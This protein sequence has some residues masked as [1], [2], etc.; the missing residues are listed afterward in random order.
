[1]NFHP[2]QAVTQ[3]QMSSATSKVLTAKPIRIRSFTTHIDVDAV[4]EKI[5]CGMLYSA[6]PDPMNRAL[7]VFVQPKAA[8]EFFNACH[9]EP[10]IVDGNRLSVDFVLREQALVIPPLLAREI[11][12]SGWTRVLGVS[13]PSNLPDAWIIRPTDFYDLLDRPNGGDLRMSKLDQLSDEHGVPYELYT[14]QYS[15]VALCIQAR[16]AIELNMT[17]KWTGCTTVRLADPCGG[18]ELPSGSDSTP[19]SVDTIPADPRTYP[20]ASAELNAPENPAAPPQA[21]SRFGSKTTSV[22]ITRPQVKLFARIDP[23]AECKGV[24]TNSG[25]GETG[26]EGKELPLPTPTMPQP[27][28]NGLTDIASDP[29]QITVKPVTTN[30]TGR[31]HLQASSSSVQETRQINN[32][33]LVDLAR[34]L[35]E[36]AM[37][38]AAKA[39]AGESAF[40]NEETLALL[41]DAIGKVVELKARLGNGLQEE[42]LSRGDGEKV[43]FT[44]K[45]ETGPLATSNGASD[46]KRKHQQVFDIGGPRTQEKEKA[47]SAAPKAM[48]SPLRNMANEFLDP[49][50]PTPFLTAASVAEPSIHPSPTLSITEESTPVMAP[51]A[52][53]AAAQN[54]TQTQSVESTAETTTSP[55]NP[56][57]EDS[58]TAQ[59]PPPPAPRRKGRG[60][61]T[62]GR[63]GLGASKWAN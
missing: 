39:G 41:N 2:E 10:L 6:T 49:Y 35:E 25:G 24:T 1:M 8:A 42:I 18:L 51:A 59:K 16:I 28:L 45:E 20:I 46:E 33:K 32:E 3:P 52:P 43:E 4:V 27:E 44:Q 50:T 15:S 38:P 23:A 21:N 29:G 34:R 7:H 53:A 56:E 54:G 31:G 14:V 17:G 11:F 58:S 62:F 22:T 36:A 63:G 12:V 55:Q 57:K 5:K 47:L 40:S 60:F 48:E 37:T 26:N 9:H 61:S 13:R 30:P 19:G